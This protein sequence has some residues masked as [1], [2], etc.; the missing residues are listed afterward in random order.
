[1]VQALTDWPLDEAI[2]LWLM[3]LEGPT[4]ATRRLATEQLQAR[5][6]SAAEL[7]IHA[8]QETLAAESA[9]LRAAWQREFGAEIASRLAAGTGPPAGNMAANL[10]AA[11]QTIERLAAGTVH[12]RRAAARELALE[13]HESRLPDEALLRL[14]ELLEV[15][16]DPLVWN[17]VLLLI[18]RDDRPS[19]ADLAAIAS[20]HPTGEVRRRACAYFG[21]H[22]GTRAAEVLLNSLSDEDTSVVRQAI[23]SLGNQGRISDLAPLEALLTSTD[24]VLRL[25]AAA[26][27]AQLG[28]SSG[29]R[30]LS[31]LT[32]HQ[33]PAIRRQAERALK[34]ESLSFLCLLRFRRSSHASAIHLNL[35]NA[36]RD[37]SRQEPIWMSPQRRQRPQRE[38][39]FLR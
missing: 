36:F 15:E 14:R 13:H 8:S 33:D 2:L 30:A 19:A 12:E 7:S 29:L 11:V 34:L 5:W 27:L 18:G 38:L 23:R 9:R 1:M 24:S 21:E 35:W 17:D 6:P 25:E 39:R 28:S 37:E 31:R 10:D 26:S 3:A 4:A 22:P 32:A 20:S 16:T